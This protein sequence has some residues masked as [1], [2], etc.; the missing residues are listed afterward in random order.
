LAQH[1]PI[2]CTLTAAELPG[3]MASARALG[4]EALVD[5]EVVDRR[6][7][8]RF[9]GHRDEVEALVAAE[10]ECCG[11][12]DFSVREYGERIELEITTPEGGEQVLRGLVAGVVAGWDGG[13]R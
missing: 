12:F 3:R 5:V 9:T 4:E 6:A 1:A 2:A 10:R 11:F 8:L 7:L 13:L